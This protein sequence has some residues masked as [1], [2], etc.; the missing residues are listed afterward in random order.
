MDQTNNHWSDS[1]IYENS[2]ILMFLWL[3]QETR[4][5]MLLYLCWWFRSSLGAVTLDRQCV[6]KKIIK[7]C[8]YIKRLFCPLALKSMCLAAF[9]KKRTTGP[10]VG[11]YPRSG[12]WVMQLNVAFYKHVC[13]CLCVWVNI[14]ASSCEWHS[15]VHIIEMTEAFCCGYFFLFFF[16]F[17][18]KA[19]TNSL[20]ENFSERS[21]FWKDPTL[22]M[23][24]CFLFFCSH[25][26]LIQRT[27]PEA[28]ESPPKTTWFCNT[29]M[30]MWE[31]LTWFEC[32]LQHLLKIVFSKCP[33]CAVMGSL[34]NIRVQIV[35]LIVAF[36]SLAW[37]FRKSS[38]NCHC[39][40]FLIW[41]T[42]EIITYMLTGI[43]WK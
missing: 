22:S 40:S 14:Q 4:L 13:T 25:C 34:C 42:K 29:H 35:Q 41:W 31:S 9:Y 39:W 5:K 23:Q 10:L 28:D 3:W 20:K 36:K 38:K 18:Q 21:S 37:S 8:Y 19:P 2:V 7:C 16:P 6:K 32:R 17:L 12:L 30:I 27:T 33:D 1:T 11:I 15:A 24:T 43:N 26:G